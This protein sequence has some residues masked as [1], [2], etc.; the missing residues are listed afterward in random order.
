MKK[1]VIPIV[2]LFF[3]ISVFGQ[4]NMTEADTILPPAVVKSFVKKFPKGETG[5]WMKENGNY[6]ISTF[7]DNTWYDITFS[8]KGKWLNSSILIDYEQLPSAVINAFE[9]STYRNHEIM[10]ISILEMPKS[11]K[12]YKL[13]LENRDGEAIILNF[14]ESGILLP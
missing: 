9:Q 11:P 2:L 7:F 5:D 12:V 10:K 8:E 14:N 6:I 13:Y 3:T 4:E 1:T